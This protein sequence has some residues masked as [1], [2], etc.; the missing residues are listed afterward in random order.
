MKTS[1]ELL[2]LVSKYGDAHMLGSLAYIR[3]AG[4]ATS[5]GAMPSS[6]A[7]AL[8][9]YDDQAKAAWATLELELAKVDKIAAIVKEWHASNEPSGIVLAKLYE[10]IEAP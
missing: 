8:K 2:L 3:G 4:I 1:K 7:T 5:R 6:E 9:T 10:L